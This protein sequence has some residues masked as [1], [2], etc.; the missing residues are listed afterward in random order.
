MASKDGKAALWVLLT[1]LVCVS[2]GVSVY[3]FLRLERVQADLS[4]QGDSVDQKVEESRTQAV[5]TSRS[6]IT[7]AEERLGR[8]IA[9]LR[10]ALAEVRTQV[11]Q[12]RQVVG[13][14]QRGYKEP[15]VPGRDVAELRKLIEEVRK[16]LNGKIDDLRRR[17]SI[18]PPERQEE[19]ERS[20]EG[21]LGRMAVEGGPG[22]RI[23]IAVKSVKI[24]PVE[25]NEIDPGEEGGAP[26]I[27]VEVYLNKSLVYTSVDFHPFGI[28][29]GEFYLENQLFVQFP[30][31][32]MKA[33]FLYPEGGSLLARVMD[34]DVGVGTSTS[35]VL[36]Q[37]P[38]DSPEG[39]RNLVTSK[40]SHLQ[41]EVSEAP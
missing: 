29:S 30:A 20:V 37:F 10:V 7:A 41:F 40:G 22:R 33:T 17:L 5:E 3:G 23:E 18:R 19:R 36:L 27:F 6:Q 24:D 35:H 1:V 34:I 4:T 9:E 26:E 8:D 32:R 28:G 12:L 14:L 16:E 21:G 13:D 2:L 11:G 38:C 25:F 15:A 39:L 31:D